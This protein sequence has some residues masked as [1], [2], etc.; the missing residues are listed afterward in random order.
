[1]ISSDIASPFCTSTATT[2][3]VPQTD[4]VLAVA[5]AWIATCVWTLIAGKDVSWDVFNHHLYIPFAWSTGRI[6][7]DFYGAGPQSYQNPLAY[8]PFYWLMRAE[9]PAWV[10]GMAL[11]TLHAI[12]ALIAYRLAR[13]LWRGQPEERFWSAVAATLAWITPVFLQTAGTSSIDPLTCALVLGGLS[14][15]F[16]GHSSAKARPYAWA[17]TLLGLAFAAK[18]SNAVFVIACGGVAVWHCVGKKSP[19][20]ALACMAG[21][22]AGIAAGMGLYSWHLWQRFGN[23]LFP[24][25]NNVFKS[26]FASQEPMLAIRFL[27]QSLADWVVRPFEMA[28]FRRYVYQE[29]FLP[30]LRPSVLLIIL[31]IG[32]ALTAVRRAR[33]AVPRADTGRSNALDVDLVVACSIGYVLWMMT[34]ANGRYGMPLLML[35]GIAL[36]R[37]AY[38]I[39]PRRIARTGMAMLMVLQIAYFMTSP[40][41]RPAAEP[42]TSGPYLDVAVPDRLRSQP[43]LHLAI[44]GALTNASL[45]PLLHPEGAFVAPVGQVSL[46]MTGPIGDEMRRRLAQWSGRTRVL[47]PAFDLSSPEFPRLKLA[48]RAMLARLGLDVDW[49]DCVRIDYRA[50]RAGTD[51][52]YWNFHP[53]PASPEDGDRKLMS[54]AAIAAPLPDA[55][56]KAEGALADRVFSALEKSCP[57]VYSPVPMATEHGLSAWERLYANTDTL[58]SVSMEKGVYSS[59]ERII[60]PRFIG[61]VDDV[62]NGRMESH[63]EAWS[64]VTPE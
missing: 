10:I 2:R 7:S 8:L 14:C 61:T 16:A 28:E 31:T 55:K 20:P 39:L 23:P 1:M 63:C 32:L 51:S 21:G 42:W 40:D 44:S 6:D 43:Y 64:L 52:W 54:C 17:G 33:A 18:Q 56:V 9:L 24:L 27:P 47:A 48:F 62:L 38:L 29:G 50:A 30:D 25:F 35:A 4:Y 37:A 53:R 45:A 57:T 36:A 3:A 13:Q 22:A 49:S 59:R 19:R 41:L 12:N 34:S 5:A 58:V 11:A 15:L 26:P 46:P 60:A